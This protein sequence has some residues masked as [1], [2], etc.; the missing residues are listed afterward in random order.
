M[1]L[2]KIPR[3]GP[4]GGGAWDGR[5]S[6]RAGPHAAPSDRRTVLIYGHYDVQPADPLEEWRTPPFDPHLSDAGV[7][8]ARGASD[9]KGQIFAHILGLEEALARAAEENSELPVNLIFLVEGEEEIGSPN[10]DAF[11]PHAPRGAALRRDRDF[12]YRHGRAGRADFHL[13]AC[14]A[15]RRWR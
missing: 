5:A 14:A 15:S 8:T 9:N 10:L 13:L 12:R 6:H 7:I 3:D 2:D 11:S 1:A 4:A